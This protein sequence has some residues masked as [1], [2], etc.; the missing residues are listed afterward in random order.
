MNP[1]WLKYLPAVIH[2]KLAGRHVMHSII[3]NS[4]WLF[5]DKLMR[6]G[7]GLF[8]GVWI[9]RYLG[10]DAFGQLNYVFA[11]VAL[12]GAISTL[13]MDGLIIREVVRRPEQKNEI[14]GTAFLLRIFAGS[15]AFSF[16][17]FAVWWLRPDDRLSILM[18]AIVAAGLIFQ[19]TDTIDLWFQS[20]V[21]VKY[22]VYARSFAFLVG[23]SIKI[24][25]ILTSASLVAFAWVSLGEVVIASLGLLLVYR[26]LG[27]RL[28]QWQFQL[29]WL[30]KLLNE[31]WPLLLSALT[32]M[33]YIRLDLIMLS[34]MVGNHEAGIYAAATRVSEIWYFLPTILVASVSPA[35][36]K[37]RE[38]D[39]AKYTHSF[40]KLYFVLVCLAIGIA[41]PLSLLSDQII[42]F[43]YGVQYAPAGDVLAIHLWASLA[44]FLGVASGQYMLIEHLQRFSFYRTLIGLI[45]NIML[46]LMLIP[47]MGAVGAA[48]AT[49]ISY[50]VAV[51]SIV[52]FKETRNHAITL[53]ESLSVVAFIKNIQ[54]SK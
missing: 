17:V 16:A 15:I 43:L 37:Q 32:V 34:E 13:G 38:T 33:L 5:A 14:L 49:V 31:S 27:G 9:A 30:K 28:M 39:L 42:G 23:A 3:S 52:L 10:P 29:S 53:F 20:Q 12:F 4:G 50:L 18:V 6:M 11:F 21:L 8:V 25:L 19:V 47:S 48:I 22:S 45:C 35:M 41:L 44:V 24:W 26:L 7:I 54:N 51:F 2:K 1:F 46:N 36:I 40:R